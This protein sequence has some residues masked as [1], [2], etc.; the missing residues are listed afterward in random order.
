MPQLQ[1]SPQLIVASSNVQSAGD[2]KDETVEVISSKGPI[3]DE[4]QLQ[5]RKFFPT[6]T[7]KAAHQTPLQKEETL[8]QGTDQNTA[9]K[10]KACLPSG[11]VLLVACIVLGSNNPHLLH[12][13]L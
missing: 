5:R 2:G 12:A 6:S 1:L 4:N 13:I 3:T 7:V 10:L 11:D 8:L 9:C